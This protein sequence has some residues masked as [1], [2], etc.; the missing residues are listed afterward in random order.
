MATVYT[1]D[2]DSDY[3]WDLSLEDEELLSTRVAVPVPLAPHSSPAPSSTVLRSSDGSSFKTQV[4]G[5]AAKGKGASDDAPDPLY[6]GSTR[7]EL[8]NDPGFAYNNETAIHISREAK[9]KAAVV[10]NDGTRLGF[11]FFERHTPQSLPTQAAD[12]VSYPDCMCCFS[13]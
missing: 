12:D 2:S 6:A 1:T 13:P 8:P 11:A 4:Y 5:R 9:G 7:F 3:G 10:S